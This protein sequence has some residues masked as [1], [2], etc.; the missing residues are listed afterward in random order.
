MRTQHNYNCKASKWDEAGNFVEQMK[1]DLKSLLA[2][3][4]TTRSEEAWSA[5]V[6]ARPVWVTETSCNWDTTDEALK[7]DNV[8]SCLRASGQT[9]AAGYGDGSMAAL[10]RASGIDRWSWWT[11]FRVNTTLEPHTP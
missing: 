4:A 1:A 10:D 6:N 11:T 2:T 8:E 3:T 7:P 9:S 5:W